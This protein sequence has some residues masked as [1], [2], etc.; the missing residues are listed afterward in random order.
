ML[1]RAALVLGVGALTFGVVL[2][3]V[4]EGDVARALGVL[5]R[6]WSP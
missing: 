3:W 4:W 5:G 1:L 6:W 2:G